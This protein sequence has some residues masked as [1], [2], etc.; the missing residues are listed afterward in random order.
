MPSADAIYGCDDHWWDLYSS[1]IKSKFS[2]SIWTQS[3]R[4]S[5]RYD[6]RHWAGE[7]KPGLGKTKIHFGSNSGY[8]AVNLAYLLGAKRIILLGYDMKVDGDN[9][10]FFGKHPYHKNGGSPTNSLMKDWCEKFVRLANDLKSEGVE[11][12]NAT[13]DTALT[14]FAKQNLEDIC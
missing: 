1:E 7:S 6:L 11:V 4:S 13:R 9:V 3:E 10:H 14:A 2:C 12:I 5:K 8:Q